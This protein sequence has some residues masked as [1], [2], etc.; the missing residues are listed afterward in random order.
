MDA[1]VSWDERIIRGSTAS[2]KPQDYTKEVGQPRN[3]SDWLSEDLTLANK[4]IG[5]K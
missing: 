1:L 2:S 5:L 3:T 4:H